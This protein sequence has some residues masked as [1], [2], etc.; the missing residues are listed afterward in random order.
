MLC[1]I[2]LAIPLY[3]KVDVVYDNRWVATVTL[4][5]KH[6]EKTPI[7]FMVYSNKATN[8]VFLLEYKEQTKVKID[9][10]HGRY[11]YWIFG[12]DKKTIEKGEID[13][14][15]PFE[16]VKTQVEANSL[17]FDVAVKKPEFVECYLYSAN[18]PIEYRR[19]Y[20]ESNGMI[21]FD[22]LKSQM[23]YRAEFSTKG[24]R[25][26][27]SF[28]TPLRNIAFGKPVTGSFNRLPESK[29]VD[30]STPAITRVND[31][32]I[33]WYSGMAVSEEVNMREQFV[34]INLLKKKKLKR[35][36]VYWNR[37]YYPISYDFIYS[38][39][40]KN[41]KKIARTSSGYKKIIAP[42]N[43]P[44]ML[45]EFDLLIKASYVGIQLR[46]NIK[47]HKRQAHKNYV[48]LMEIEVYE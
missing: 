30:D 10:P 48:Q 20:I 16:V 21:V 22:G 3:A 4:D 5:K 45:D 18:V 14:Q 47:I 7:V 43:S 8:T 42:D 32:R 35:V 19:Q 15:K 17:I 37:N 12:S 39:D 1:L 28:T 36:K 23:R 29:F 34:L 27:K 13:L 40:G 26:S 25:M 6:F 2:F 38:T 9:L 11:N 44:V 33:E 41:W 24:F 31:G 46:K